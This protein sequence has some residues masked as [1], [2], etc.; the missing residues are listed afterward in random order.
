[1]RWR[2]DGDRSLGH[3][4]PDGLLFH[5]PE[6]AGKGAEQ[7][8]E[9]AFSSGSIAHLADLFFWPILATQDKLLGLVLD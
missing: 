9:A 1:M 5:G 2:D 6:M 8:Q 7:Q 4:P 3:R